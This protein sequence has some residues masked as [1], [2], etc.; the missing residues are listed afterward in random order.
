MK[1]RMMSKDAMD[2]LFFHIL[3]GFRSSHEGIAKLQEQRIVTDQEIHE[4]IKK[5]SERLIDR[6]R[7][8][9]IEQKLFGVFFACLFSWMQV[10]GEELE[11]RKTIAR[12][13]VTRSAS[14][15]RKTKDEC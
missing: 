9:K 5:N 6:I 4:L 1:P 10:T 8:F 3:D 11:A 7:E 12:V 15:G 2:Q 13:H 14:R